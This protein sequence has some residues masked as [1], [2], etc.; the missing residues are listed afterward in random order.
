MSI[1]SVAWTFLAS[2]LI[3]L[4]VFSALERIAKWLLLR[5]ALR[6]YRLEIAG[7]IGLAATPDQITLQPTGVDPWNDRAAAGRLVLAVE[8]EGFRSAGVFAIDEMPGLLVQLFAHPEEKL[9]GAVYEHPQAGHWIDVVERRTD[10]TSTTWSSAPESGLDP[11]SGHL[12]VREPGAAPEALV[13]RARRERGPAPAEAVHPAEVE[14][15]FERAY[16]E[17]TA[18]RK[19]K[20]VSREEM[21]RIE[22]GMEQA[23]A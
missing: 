14:A 6:K 11:R 16:A 5:F 17:E 1:V 4:V 2:F 9:I 21:Q 20:C 3:A 15:L 23:A 8:R 22:R 13:A 19:G 12:Q 7:A 10:G 18:W